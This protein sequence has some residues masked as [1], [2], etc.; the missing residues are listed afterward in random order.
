MEISTEKGTL[1][2]V[3]QQSDTIITDASSPSLGNPN[4]GI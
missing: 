2:V 3:V 4:K 1:F